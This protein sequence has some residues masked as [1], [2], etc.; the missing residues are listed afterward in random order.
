MFK[1]YFDPVRKDSMGVR[2]G[3][4]GIKYGRNIT[5]P[6]SMSYYDKEI[7]LAK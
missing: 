5:Q 2:A 4:S 6:A 1:T 3:K 7:D